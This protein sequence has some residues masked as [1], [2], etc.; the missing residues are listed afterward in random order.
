MKTTLE[1]AKKQTNRDNVDVL[2]SIIEKNYDA[3]Q[4]YR[5]AMM[6]VKDPALKNFLQQQARQRSNFTTAIDKEIRDL[7]QTPKENGSIIGTLH[8][9]WIDIKSIV[10]G[11]DD[12]T[13]IEEVIRGEKA[14]VKEYKGIIKN[15]TL[16]PQINNMLQSQ[17]NDIKSTLNHVKT[18]EDFA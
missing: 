2:Q 11:N 6:D 1:R 9:T 14:K 5:K 18:L 10:S 17:L 4:G 12:E 13:V 7:G 16:A 3:Q 8:R 15:N